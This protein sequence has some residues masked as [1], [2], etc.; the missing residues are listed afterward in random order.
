MKAT[1]KFLAAGVLVGAALGLVYFAPAPAVAQETDHAKQIG[2]RLICMCN[3]NQILTACNHVGCTVSTVML[4]KLDQVVARN[5]SDDLS[6]QAFIQEYGQKVLAEP[7]SRG[8]NRIAWFIPGIAF[9]AGLIAVLF[10][11]QHWR[12]PSPRVADGPAV[13]S[14]ILERGRRQA[15]RE[16]EE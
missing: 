12:K 11:I 8:F 5:E 13:R 16:T 7:P 6:I 2:K 1:I 14:D 4:K 9:A 10:V 15:D 3:C